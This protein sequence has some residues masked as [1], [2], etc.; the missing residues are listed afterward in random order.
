MI[1]RQHCVPHEALE[2]QPRPVVRPG[3]KAVVDADHRVV[4]ADKAL[5]THCLVVEGGHHAQLVQNPEP[6][7]EGVRDTGL[8]AVPSGGCL[9]HRQLDGVGLL[10]LLLLLL[11]QRF[12]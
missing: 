6:A 2:Q 8:A 7:L 1:R 11:P 4:A 3:H 10:L 9:D 5:P 12:V